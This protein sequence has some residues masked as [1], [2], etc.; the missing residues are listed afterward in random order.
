MDNIF[1]LLCFMLKGKKMEQKQ[2]LM[3][4]GE[5]KVSKRIQ[6]LRRV[7]NGPGVNC[8]V[9][10]KFSIE[11]HIIHLEV[12]IVRALQIAGRDGYKAGFNNRATRDVKDKQSVDDTY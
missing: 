12:E 4:G 9:A 8:P 7:L 11:Q 5:M 6:R 3:Q 1:G 2:A 10:V